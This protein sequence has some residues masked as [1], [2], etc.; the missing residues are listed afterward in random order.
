MA[1]TLAVGT[2]VGNMVVARYVNLR[3]SRLREVDMADC[4]VGMLD[5]AGA[6]VAPSL[7]R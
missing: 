2:T 4:V 3:G 1:A 7:R 5:L 6:T